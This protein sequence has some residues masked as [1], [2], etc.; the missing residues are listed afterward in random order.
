MVAERSNLSCLLSTVGWRVRS[1]VRILLEAYVWYCNGPNIYDITAIYE[2]L[3]Y[4]NPSYGRDIFALC[5][6]GN[7]WIEYTIL[8]IQIQFYTA[9]FYGELHRISPATFLQM[10]IQLETARF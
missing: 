9:V 5:Q 10:K 8:L 6:V 3:Y 4:Y 1:Q 2:S 7:V